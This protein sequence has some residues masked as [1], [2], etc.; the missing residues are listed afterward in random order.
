MVYGAPL[1]PMYTT[2]RHGAFEYMA[3]SRRTRGRQPRCCHQVG[4]VGAGKQFA[5]R[6]VGDLRGA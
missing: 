4:S 2:A 1:R 6:D 3:F 5:K